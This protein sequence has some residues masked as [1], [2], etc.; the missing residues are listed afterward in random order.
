MGYL[1]FYLMKSGSKFSL[2]EQ[3]NS[4]LRL[5][6][7]YLDLVAIKIN[8][9]FRT[10]S[11]IHQSQFYSP[12]FWVLNPNAYKPLAS[13]SLMHISTICGVRVFWYVPLASISLMHI[14]TT[15]G[16]RGF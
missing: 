13:I 6:Y 3:L 2:F 7:G 5:L 1:Q 15:C 14:S 12:L 11:F 16:M 4:H 10:R 8:N 9:M